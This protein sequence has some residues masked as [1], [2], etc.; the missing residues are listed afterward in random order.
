MECEDLVYK[1]AEA[2]YDCGD[3]KYLVKDE[4]NPGMGACLGNYS[5]NKE[6]SWP[7]ITRNRLRN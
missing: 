1:Y 4:E 5:I 7:L 2:C 3:N 6:T